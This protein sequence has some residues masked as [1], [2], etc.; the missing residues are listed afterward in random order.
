VR[1]TDEGVVVW[2][3]GPSQPTIERVAEA[4]RDKLVRRHVATELL[5]SNTA[6][7]DVLAGHGFERRVAFAAERL[8]HHGIAVVV[9]IP[10]PSRNGR[11]EIRA[12]L[13]RFIEVYVPVGV[14]SAAYEPP[15]RPEV[16]I[17]FPESELDVAVE[18]TLRTLELLGYLKPG[19]DAAY[20]ADEEREVIRRLKS[21]GYL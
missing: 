12:W 10:S 17:D 4:I 9:A 6:G 3:T 13:R 11:D 8:V 7:I 19:S 15:G 14:G 2:V 20:S 16:Q 1:Q 18:R 21:F 5:G